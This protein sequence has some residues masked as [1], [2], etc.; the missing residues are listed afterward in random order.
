MSPEDSTAGAG[1]PDAT[2][3]SYG[4]SWLAR[5]E[6]GMDQL[7][8]EG[9]VASPDELPNLVAKAAAV[10]DAQDAM[11]YL[12]DLQQRVLVPFH[13]PNSHH[14]GESH[15]VLGVDST[16][17]GR[18]FQQMQQVTQSASPRGSR[19]RTRIWLPLLDGTERLGVLGMLLPVAVLDEAKTRRLQRFASVV[20]ELVMTK[21]LY[22]DS[23]IRTRRTTRMAL[24]AEV[25]W[26][27]LPPLTFS[28]HLVTVAGGLEPAYEVAGDSLDYAVDAGFARFAVFDGMGHGIV[29]A[30]LISLVVAAYRN[31]RRA[32]QTLADTAAHIES[33]VNDV[34]RVESFA[35]GLL[36]ELD[37]TN[38]VLTWISAGHH[39]PLL[40]R[41]GRLVRALVTEPL[42]PLGLNHDLAHSTKAPIGEAHLQPG[43]MLLLYT[44]GVI[45]ARSPDGEFFGQERLVDLVSRHL[46]SGLPA[47]EVMRRVVHA[48]LDHQAGD[49]DDDATLLLVEWH[50]PPGPNNDPPP[51]SV[52]GERALNPEMSHLTGSRPPL[53]PDTGHRQ[54]G[55]NRS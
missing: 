3:A 34:F 33:A 38:G 32:G 51:L 49:L 52:T 27:L 10:F 21:T 5:L 15:H 45:E 24:A 4:A 46:V 20:A 2:G 36:C 25:Q 53:P 37:T 54:V 7:I 28:N 18:A 26:S 50:G 11:I 22:G 55:G 12:A 44:D 42:L 16:V 23:I 40:L 31:A 47:P 35:T 17:A 9:H 30:Q 48:L 41:D 14:H 29:S 6:T 19:D 43:D 39:E 13:G 1:T 8:Y